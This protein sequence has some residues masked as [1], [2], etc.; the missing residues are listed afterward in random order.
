MDVGMIV[1]SKTGHTQL[2]AE[3]LKERLEAGGHSVDMS[4][5]SGGAA[6]TKADVLVFCSPIHGGAPAEIM[7]Q[8]I[9]ASDLKGRQAI[10]LMTG[11]M[12]RKLR[13]LAV[14][15][16]QEMLDSRGADVVGGTSIGWMGR[17]KRP[18]RIADAAERI[19]DCCEGRCKNG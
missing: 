4:Q 1:Y 12:W 2:A 9:H 18:Q 8:C 14:H 17:R 15:N 7:Q 6:E 16:M 10:V 5:T 11:A 19:A 13:E 3:K